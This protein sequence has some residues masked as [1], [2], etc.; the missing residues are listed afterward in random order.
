MITRPPLSYPQP[1]KPVSQYLLLVLIAIAVGANFI[2]T[3]WLYVLL[4]P[5][6]FTA[7]F[8]ENAT[9]ENIQKITLAFTAI[10]GLIG[11]FRRKNKLALVL[12]YCLITLAVILF[13]RESPNCHGLVASPMVCVEKSVNYSISG[14]LLAFFAIR[15]LLVM[16]HAPYSAFQFLRPYFLWPIVFGIAM[17]L[18]S[19][20]M[21]HFGLEWLEE[22]LE[23][24][25]Y[26]C[27][28]IYAVLIVFRRK[29][30]ATAP[31][32]ALGRGDEGFVWPSE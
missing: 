19:Q 23:Q 2:F 15:S 20:A 1:S 24:I 28:A 18:M 17:G 14:V 29:D 5:P 21:E 7:F 22:T 26:S 4:S 9:H 6:D 3:A 13:L 31:A 11:L 12:D 25:A 27:F 32:E 16:R 10:I 8:K 30:L